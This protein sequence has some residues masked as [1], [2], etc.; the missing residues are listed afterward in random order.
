ML[1]GHL[2]HRRGVRL[3]QTLDL[4]QQS[5]QTLARVS[6]TP[7][8]ICRGRPRT[9]FLAGEADVTMRGMGMKT[10]SGRFMRPW[11]DRWLTGL[12]ALRAVAWL[13][14][15]LA[16]S[17][18]TNVQAQAACTSVAVFNHPTYQAFR[19]NSASGSCT[20]PSGIVMTWD[21][22]G[23]NRGLT[24]FGCSAYDPTYWMDGGTMTVTFSAPVNDVGFIIWGLDG[25]DSAAVTVGSSSAQ[26]APLALSREFVDLCPSRT[27]GT[28]PDVIGNVVQG[29]GTGYFG[30][31][32]VR[33]SDT[34]PYT[35]MKL[36]I[37]GSGGGFGLVAVSSP[38]PIVPGGPPVTP[39]TTEIPT[40]SE[41]GM[42]ALALLLALGGGWAAR[43][44][45][46]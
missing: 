11:S 25:G 27:G 24:S 8:G 32:G 14:P 4:H 37:I 20:L 39:T 31:I 10:T 1:V 17:H 34:G 28:P 2:H 46:A 12:K 30:Q 7:L 5:H 44:R 13:L 42:I 16:L 18:G 23:A 45:R 3:P 38:V 33:A 22:V 26:A 41:W 35:V 43:R 40:L 6:E 9:T 19:T 29:S 21:H 15:L 36:A